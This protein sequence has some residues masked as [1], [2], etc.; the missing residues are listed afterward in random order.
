MLR[1]SLHPKP[2]FLHPGS[3]PGFFLGA[4]FRCQ[5][6]PDATPSPHYRRMY[7]GGMAAEDPWT[8]DGLEPGWSPSGKPAAA[9]RGRGAAS[10]P[11]NRFEPITIEHDEE[12]PPG[13]I[14]TRYLVDGSK[15]VIAS[16]NSPDVG[17]D[18]SINPYRGCEHGCIYCY[19]RPTHEFFGL[20]SGLDFESVIFAKKDAPQQLRKEL[21]ARSF[22][23]QVIALSGVTDPYQPIEKKLEITRG[24]LEVLAEARC[25][26]GVITKNALVLR[27]IDILRRL[28]EH[29]AVSVALSVTTL[30]GELARKL[31]PRASHPLKRIEAIAKLRE[32][33]ILAGVMTAPIIPAITDHEIPALLEAAAE[34]GA[35]FAGYT[36]IR[37]PYAI[38]HLFK[39]WLENH[40]PDRA[41]KVLGRLREMRGGD[42][43]NDP[44]FGTRMRGEGIWA[45]Q[46]RA[47]FKM[48]V[49]RLG[50]DGRTESLQLS[51]AAFR[52][53]A[54]LS[55]GVQLGLFGEA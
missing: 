14:P 17:F 16:N 34:A 21:R 41:A 30:D 55:P 5:P 29:R 48:H 20:S 32:A 42:K 11:A 38:E 39:E 2:P 51:A 47:M 37:L 54:D 24:C 27:D 28:A 15:T 44:R 31:E 4:V 1:S 40:F 45:D 52:P 8:D 22:K 7:N 26:V 10:N 46:I 12:P 3:L 50:L 6:P 25:P 23:P 49:R 36:V 18:I 35:Q 43:L 19:A 13:V 33:G 53:P 9:L